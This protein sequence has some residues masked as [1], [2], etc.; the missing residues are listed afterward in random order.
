M[1]GRYALHSRPEVIALAFGLSEAPATLVPRF[2]I[3]PAAE[4][5]IVRRETGGAPRPALVRW[6]LLPRWAKD[7]KRAAKLN[8]AR[9]E[10][11]AEKPSFRDAYRRRRC[12]VP[13]NGF[14]EWKRVESRKQP[15][16]VY[17][18]QGE[19]FAFAGLWERWEGASGPLETCAIVTTQAN[20]PMQAIH[21][22]MPVIL[23]PRDYARWLDCS[24]DAEV[25]DLLVPCRAEVIRVHAVSTAVNRAS[26]DV[27]ELI[28]P[29]E[30]A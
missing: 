13:A 22:R 30:Q 23:A 25:T 26:N 7:P 16:Y 15:Y 21:D 14:Y 5:L 29:L 10:T 17:P 1:C 2:N 28:E 6:G 8:N 20:A 4:V 18:A 11:V 3:A 27:R 9:G 19:L 24:A 12:L